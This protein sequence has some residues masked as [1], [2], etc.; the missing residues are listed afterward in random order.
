MAPPTKHYTLL[1]GYVREV[2]RDLVER[3]VI[4]RRAGQSLDAVITA[5][6][7]IVIA[8]VANDFRTLG[9]E[10]GMTILMGGSTLLESFAREKI[11]GAANTVMEAI[12]H[13]VA[14]QYGS[15]KGPVGR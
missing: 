4:R 5:E 9:A 2:A 3:G 13:A 6:S 11:E 8:E 14:D 15:K 1:R 7:Q 10:L 12:R